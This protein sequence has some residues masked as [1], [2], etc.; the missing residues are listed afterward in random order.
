MSPRADLLEPLS[1]VLARA[2]AKADAVAWARG[3]AAARRYDAM[4]ERIRRRLAAGEA[5]EPKF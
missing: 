4:V 3:P 2:Q 5:V 1:R